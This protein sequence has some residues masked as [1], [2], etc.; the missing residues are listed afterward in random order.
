M[1]HHEHIPIPDLFAFV[2]RSLTEGV[3][4]IIISR[5]ADGAT[6]T[7]SLQRHEPTAEL[8]MRGEK[9]ATVDRGE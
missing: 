4:I 7:V 3:Q 8:L 9:G 5:N 2:Q 1:E 6:C